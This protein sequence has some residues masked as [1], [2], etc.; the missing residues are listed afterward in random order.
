MRTESAVVQYDLVLEIPDRPDIALPG[1]MLR[2][3]EK[4][5]GGWQGTVRVNPRLSDAGEGLQA[6]MRDGL[7]PGNA[8]LVKL[9]IGGGTGL[10]GTAVR[11]WPSVVASIA[12]EGSKDVNEPDAVCLVTVRDP[13]TFLGDRPVWAA[14]VECPPGRMLGGILS[15]AAGQDGRPTRN[16]IL[17]GLPTV[18]IHEEL[19]DEVAEAGYAI[20]VGEPL[21]RWLD[22]VFS[23]LGIRIEMIGDADGTLHMTV[24]DRVPSGTRV[25]SDGGLDM[26]RDANREPG[27]TN[28]VLSEVD[29]N[30]PAIV[31]GGLLDDA[32]GGGPQRFGPAGGL[33]T[34]LIERQPS[35][36]EA[37]R[38][39]GFRQANR[40]L[41]QA[42]VTFSSCQPG[43]VPGRVVNLKPGDPVA[44][45]SHPLAHGPPPGTT[46]PTGEAVQGFPAA[47]LGARQWQVADV[48]HL[49]ERARYR[50]Q[51]TLEKTGLAWRPEPPPERGAIMISGVVDDG[52]SAAGELVRRD[53]LGRIPVRLSFIPQASDSSPA[54]PPDDPGPPLLPLSPLAPGAGNQHGFVADH[55]QGDWCRVSVVNPLF[56]EITGYSHRDDRHLGES[57][58]DATVGFVVREEFGEWH[59]M[60]FR[61]DADEGDAGAADDSSGGGPGS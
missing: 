56:A 40:R 6:L 4:R 7:V 61:P 13:L 20:A 51:A 46:A 60:L 26:T 53:R 45:R 34:V 1:L 42:R 14:F 32:A 38:R 47:L 52:A 10:A 15:C 59:G 31:R 25:N 8:V 22:R 39:A 35:A 36:D 43:L 16:P 5:S 3:T 37:A 28:L 12:T 44:H 41:K 54:R 17:P 19:R 58:R 2:L 30:A 49:C 48:A 27:A 11:T 18:R 55:R 24:C 33:E 21:G 9:L 23:R 57:V 29:V 50:N